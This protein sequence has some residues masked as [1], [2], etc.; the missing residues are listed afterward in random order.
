MSQ[1]IPECEN[2]QQGRCPKSQVT[3]L[4]EHGTTQAAWYWTFFCKTCRSAF[5][6]WNPSVVNAA[7]NQQLDKSIG[8]L[9]DKSERFKGLAEEAMRNRGLGVFN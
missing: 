8:Q 3:M 4:A 2:Y 9:S 7:K 6:K 1:P 5:I